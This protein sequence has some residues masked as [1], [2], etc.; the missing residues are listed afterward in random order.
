MRD[1]QRKKLNALGHMK[2]TKILRF[3]TMVD[4]E[5]P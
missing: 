2:P 5:I 1:T 4:A 3:Q